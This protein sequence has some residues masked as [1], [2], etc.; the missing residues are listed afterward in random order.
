MQPVIV[1]VLCVRLLT[2]GHVFIKG[3]FHL[4]EREGRSVV[5]CSERLPRPSGPLKEFHDLLELVLGT[6]QT[7]W[8]SLVPSSEE[9]CILIGQAVLASATIFNGR[10]EA[11]VRGWLGELQWIEAVI[12]DVAPDRVR[13]GYV[14]LRNF[15][16]DGGS[17]RSRYSRLQ[18]MFLYSQISFFF[19]RVQ[20]ERLI[21]RDLP[22]GTRGK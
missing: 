10:R 6:A 7:K 16:T 14:D 1:D 22:V 2:L 15:A 18:M 13:S 5:N 8:D 19:S 9:G 21:S 11:N 4:L 3:A 20:V 12:L 17:L